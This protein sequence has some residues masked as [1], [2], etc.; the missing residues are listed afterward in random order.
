MLIGGS[1]LEFPL[2]QQ[3]NMFRVRTW[4]HH[5]TLTV[6]AAILLP[7]QKQSGP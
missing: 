4:R 3:F 6:A 1:T 5:R 7:P 2:I